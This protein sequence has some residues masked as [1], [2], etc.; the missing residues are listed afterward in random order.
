MLPRIV[1]ISGKSH[2]KPLPLTGGLKRQFGD[3]PGSRSAS[4]PPGS[5]IGGERMFFGKLGPC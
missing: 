3:A 5:A 1:G 4:G 2:R